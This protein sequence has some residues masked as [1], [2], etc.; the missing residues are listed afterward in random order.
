MAVTLK[1]AG[2]GAE[3]VAEPEQAIRLLERNSYAV[4]VTT[5]NG[6]P[7]PGGANLYKRIVALAPEVRRDLFLILV[8]SELNSGDGMQAFVAMADLVLNPKDAAA[9]EELLR[10][11]M[12]ER[13]RL[14][15]AFLEAQK[16]LDERRY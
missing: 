6:E 2:Y 7:A 5:N 9:S 3:S 10:S 11:T 13:A 14:Y 4:V 16:R 15:Q 1:R 12:T 8:G